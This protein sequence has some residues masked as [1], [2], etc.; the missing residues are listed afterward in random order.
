MSG[1]SLDGI[2]VVFA[3]F[4]ENDQNSSFE[5]D[6]SFAIKY[7]PEM[8]ANLAKARSFTPEALL[9]LE[10]VFGQW[11]ADALSKQGLK[12]YDPSFIATHGHTIFHNPSKHYS[13]Q[14]SGAHQLCARLN[15]PVIFD[16]RMSDIARGGQGAPLVP[17]G[18]VALFKEYDAFIN[19]G[20]IAN[21]TFTA[22]EVRAWDIV[23]FNQV[24][25]ALS[26]KLGLAYDP[27][28]KNA[29]KGKMDHL[30]YE[31]WSSHSFFASDP[32]KS[33]SNEWVQKYFLE[34]LP[35]PFDGLHTYCHFAADQIATTINTQPCM[36]S[37][38]IVML[39]GGGA[40]NS[41]FVELLKEKSSSP[42]IIPSQE[43]IEYK[44]ALIFAFLGLL[45]WKGKTNVLKTVT[46][47]TQDTTAGTIILP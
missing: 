45:R 31:K 22:P 13:C 5:I 32:P 42:V 36:N 19:L 6:R 18:E 4:A 39:S 29:R 11:L 8:R 21:I 41:Y 17:A 1:S 3:S 40:Y 16:F 14:L 2:D 27:E 10:H 30:W 20:G 23:P 12:D 44:E 25:N 43:I 26:D 47:A 15:V 37:K 38:R 46:G 24:L 34:K 28:G 9:E 33:I 35:G 7:T